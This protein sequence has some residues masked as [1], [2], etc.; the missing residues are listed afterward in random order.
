[1]IGLMLVAGLCELWLIQMDYNIRVTDEYEIGE[2]PDRPWKA[3]LFRRDGVAL[4]NDLRYYAVL[5]DNSI[6]GLSERGYFWGS[7]NGKLTFYS[8]EGLWRDRCYQASGSTPGVLRRPGR[9]D[10]SLFWKLQ[11]G[12]LVISFIV[13]LRFAVSYRNPLKAKSLSH[14]AD[15]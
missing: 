11:V 5:P 1:M 12:L 15:S 6:G 8:D 13:I 9:G 3:T 10:F 2:T 4:V 7:R 14:K